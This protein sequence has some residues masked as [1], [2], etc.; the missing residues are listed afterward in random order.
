MAEATRAVDQCDCIILDLT[1]MYWYKFTLIF[2]PAESGNAS[3][4]Y[5]ILASLHWL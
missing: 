1:Q 5:I 2:G 4:M 3:D